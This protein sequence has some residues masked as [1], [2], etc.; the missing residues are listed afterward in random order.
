MTVNILAIIY[1][2][3]DSIIIIWYLYNTQIFLKIYLIIIRFLLIK[4]N[5][6]TNL[7]FKNSNYILHWQFIVNFLGKFFCSL[8]MSL[9]LINMSHTS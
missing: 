3:C 7:V 6:E 8:K 5:L 4:N 2:L 9:D 1:L